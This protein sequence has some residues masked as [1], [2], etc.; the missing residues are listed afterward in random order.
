[1]FFFTASMVSCKKYLDAIPNTNLSTISGIDDLQSLLD[2]YSQMNMQYPVPIELLSDDYFVNSSDWASV[3]DAV[4]RSLYLWQNNDNTDTYWNS[5][6]KTILTANIVLDELTK[7]DASEDER[8]VRNNVK[9]SAL[10]FRAYYFY[11]LAQLFAKPYS[12]TAATDLGIV[13]KLNSDIEERSVRASVFQTYKQIILDFKASADLLPDKPLIKTRPS[14]PAAYGAIARTYLA[15][16]QYDSAGKYA[17]LC[18]SIHDSLI[19][20]NSLN[21]A[22]SAPISRFNEEVIFQMRTPVAVILSNSRAKIDTQLYNSYDD[23]DLRKV[24]FFKPNPDGSYQFKGDYD[25]TGVTNYAFTGVVS[26]EMYLIRSECYARSGDVAK[27][28]NDLNKLLRHRYR[29]GHFTDITAVNAQDALA[30]IIKERRKELYRRGIRW[31]DIRRFMN[32]PAFASI[33]KRVINTQEYLM[34]T[35]SSPYLMLLP[36]S[37]II[38]SGM[39]QN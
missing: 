23:H 8:E 29:E 9:G 34:S 3:N 1:M 14:K 2:H 39:P 24:V 11:A 36:K 10:F 33:P 26:D 13:L 16:N 20:Y 19:N 32:E 35:G 12:S 22:V 17:N 15:M 30:K 27:A 7:I 6:Y 5:P 18:L 28:L 37:I 21:P 4:Q 31:T 38:M 25:G